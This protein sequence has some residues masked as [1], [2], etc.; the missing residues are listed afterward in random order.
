MELKGI[1]R[2]SAVAITA[3]ISISGWVFAGV[4]WKQRETTGFPASS[5]M[6]S[7]MENSERTP[8]ESEQI[9]D[10]SSITQIIISGSGN[11]FY[12]DGETVMDGQGKP[13]LD[14]KGYTE[15]FL[16]DSEYYIKPDYEGER[17]YAQ[18]DGKLYF[19][20]N[21]RYS[22]KYYETDGTIILQVDQQTHAL[23]DAQMIEK[24]RCR[25]VKAHK[26]D[27]YLLGSDFRDN[28]QFWLYRFT[29]IPFQTAERRKVSSN[30][31]MV[32]YDLSIEIDQWDVANIKGT[33]KPG[34]YD[35]ASVD[36]HLDRIPTLSRPGQVVRIEDEFNVPPIGKY[37]IKAGEYDALVKDGD[38][39]IFQQNVPGETTLSLGKAYAALPPP[40][41]EGPGEWWFPIREIEIFHADENAMLIASHRG[42]NLD[43]CQSAIDLIDLHGGQVAASA[44]YDGAAIR[45]M[46]VTD[47]EVYLF[48][49]IEMNVIGE[50]PDHLL[51]VLDRKTL[52]EKNRVGVSYPGNKAP[53]MSLNENGDIVLEHPLRRE[54]IQIV[55]LVNS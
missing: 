43:N 24:L 33:P 18:C 8:F 20:L 36:V 41:P 9:I 5:S 42:S 48:I 29:H 6:E 12:W 4:Q 11:T 25:A 16:A 21:A 31:L 30:A 14:I 7:D 15:D 17:Y 40:D 55:E 39:I 53:N 47:T 1:N 13:F 52:E 26:Q 45:N 50:Q 44:A 32:R 46:L 34:E 49:S 22:A 37:I 27:L 28:A 23:T 35:L 2:Y 19:I 51:V 3:I 54:D 38:L 10:I